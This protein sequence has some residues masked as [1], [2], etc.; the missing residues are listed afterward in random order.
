M[1]CWGGNCVVLMM[2]DCCPAEIYNIFVPKFVMP[3]VDHLSFLSCSAALQQCDN[4]CLMYIY[5]VI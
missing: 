2:N 5:E 4:E 3:H 1:V